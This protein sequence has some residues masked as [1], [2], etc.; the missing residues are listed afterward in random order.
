MERYGGK[1]KEPKSKWPPVV[2][3]V[4]CDKPESKLIS[5]EEYLKVLEKRP[6]LRKRPDLWT[7]GGDPLN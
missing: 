4:R 6:M 5:E 7:E 3:P 2:A 1:G